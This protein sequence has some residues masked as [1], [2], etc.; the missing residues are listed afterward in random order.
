MEL[1]EI[2]ASRIHGSGVFAKQDIKKGTRVIEYVGEKIT[3]KESDKRCDEQLETGKKTGGGIVY[4]FEL[5][6]KY[7]IDGNVP[8]NPARLIN[9]SC[10]P[11]CEAEIDKGHIWIVA[12]RDIKKGEELSYDYGYDFDNWEEHPCRCGAKTCLGYI[13]AKRDRTKLKKALATKT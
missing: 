3:K 4:I 10:D 13:V 12:M 9:H 5:N 7:D 11:N 6:K 2:R 8:W 1:Y